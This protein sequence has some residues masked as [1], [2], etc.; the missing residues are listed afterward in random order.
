MKK[1]SKKKPI[2]SQDQLNA[3][4]AVSYGST[5]G[6][7]QLLIYQHELLADL[8]KKGFADVTFDF[9]AKKLGMK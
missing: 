6:A 3:L 5:Y 8:V 4:K 9:K 7:N 1:K 2:L